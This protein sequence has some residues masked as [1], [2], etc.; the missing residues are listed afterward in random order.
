MCL[1]ECEHVICACLYF[2]LKASALTQATAHTNTRT[3]LHAHTHS[4]T[5]TRILSCA[6]THT[7]S[8]MSH[9]S[10][11]HLSLYSILL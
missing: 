10:S 3:C 1:N 7:H 2:V 8:Y 5:H 11:T 4:F 9:E 6:H